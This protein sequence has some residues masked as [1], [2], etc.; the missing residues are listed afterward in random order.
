MES[1]TID[2]PLELTV[3][4]IGNK[5]KPLI[6]HY[7]MDGTMRFSELQHAIPQ[8]SQKIL[9]DNLRRLESDGLI[10]RA[11]FAEVPPRV[12][13][14]LTGIGKTLEPLISIMQQW[15]LKYQK[16]TEVDI[17]ENA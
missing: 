12:E 8:I 6:I 1:K 2:C 5:W 3:S 7:L 14:T 16:K 15:G 9:T 13:Y 4:L 11:I 17:R 10:S